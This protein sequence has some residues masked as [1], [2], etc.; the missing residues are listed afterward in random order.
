[1]IL[2][3]ILSVLVG[4]AIL[5]GSVLIIAVGTAI[6]SYLHM[7]AVQW[8]YSKCPNC[9]KRSMERHTSGPPCDDCIQKMRDH[10]PPI[11]DMAYAP[12]PFPV[13]VPLP[14][15]LTLDANSGNLAAD[16]AKQIVK[17]PEG[18][19]AFRKLVGIQSE[20]EMW[21]EEDAEKDREL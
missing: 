18:L 13:S 5:F 2:H 16:F 15:S 12:P 4:A 7:R 19:K 1:M 17:D 3:T 21:E 9:H 10:C 8:L 20:R 14:T 6:G 11:D